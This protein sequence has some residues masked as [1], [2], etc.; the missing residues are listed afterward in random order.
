MGRKIQGNLKVW[1][2]VLFYIGLI[3]D[4][5]G[6]T[7]KTNLSDSSFWS[8]HRITGLIAIILM[9][10][11]ALWA[12]YVLVKK[13]NDKIHKFHK[14]SIFVWIIWLIQYFIGVAIGMF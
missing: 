5:I 14:F 8:L 6:T 2:L 3:Y 10:I 9:L 7:M 1:H 12:T 4:T 11:H 13:D